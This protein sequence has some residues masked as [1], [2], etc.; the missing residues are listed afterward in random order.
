MSIFIFILP[1]KYGVV[2]GRVANSIILNL[3]EHPRCCRTRDSEFGSLPLQNIYLTRKCT[4]DIYL[5]LFSDAEALTLRLENGRLIL[6]H[7]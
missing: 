4:L 5:P 2:N 7:F 6:K 1:K 3:K